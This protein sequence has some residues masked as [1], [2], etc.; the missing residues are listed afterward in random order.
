MEILLQFITTFSTKYIIYQIY[1]LVQFVLIAGAVTHVRMYSVL[2]QI[3]LIKQSDIKWNFIAHWYTTII[4]CSKHGCVNW[5][6][7]VL[8]CYKKHQGLHSNLKTLILCWDRLIL[9]LT[10]CY[11]SKMLS[12]NILF[13]LNFWHFSKFI[14]LRNKLPMGDNV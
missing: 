4:L 5:S 12:K 13:K 3:T 14:T 1:N 2:S 6:K 10:I 8:G 11:I 7:Y 9:L